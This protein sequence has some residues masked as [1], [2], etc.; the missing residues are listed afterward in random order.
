MTSAETGAT[1]STADVFLPVTETMFSRAFD[2]ADMARAD[3]LKAFRDRVA[4]DARP[5]FDSGVAALS[6]GDLATAE[7]SFKSALGTDAENTS[8]LAYLA[9]VFAAAGRD[10][11]AT[12]AW[13]TSL[14]DG[15][16]FPEIYGWLGDALLREHRM[17]E[18]R[19]I[20][21]EAV[22][23]W[24]GDVR[25]TKPLAILYATFGQGQRAVRL[26]ERYLETHQDDPEALQLGVEWIYHLKLAHAAARTPA[27]DA[28]LARTYANA[29]EKAKGPQLALVNQW[30]AYLERN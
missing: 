18:A 16:D 9:A 14:V 12:G 26:L 15:S 13:Q 29:Y 25:F 24:P 20:L 8:V 22:T 7:T 11:Q 5:A 1:L 4:V 19:A 10:D 23:K 3:T 28:Q 6:S 21:E 27:D 30:L 17:A 2:K